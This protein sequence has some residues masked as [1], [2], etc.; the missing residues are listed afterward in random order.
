MET[1]I[2]LNTDVKNQ[3]DKFKIHAR[4]SYNEVLRRLIEECKNVGVDSESLTETIEILS[5]PETLR[6]IAEALNE[7]ESGKSIPWEKIK[8]END[9]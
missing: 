1:T 5:E 3:L 6:E 2:R 8:K 4:E 9:L 7:F